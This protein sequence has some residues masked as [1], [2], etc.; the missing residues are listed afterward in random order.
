MQESPAFL[1]VKVRGP[2][3]EQDS[4]LDHK[5]LTQLGTQRWGRSTEVA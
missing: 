5:E 3:G 4:A 2:Q 1:G